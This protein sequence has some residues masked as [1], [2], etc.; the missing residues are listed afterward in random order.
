MGLKSLY[1]KLF[2]RTK[3]NVINPI[4]LFYISWLAIY[5][6]RD[7]FCFVL[8]EYDHTSFLTLTTVLKKGQFPDQPLEES[9]TINCSMFSLN[10]FTFFS[11]ASRIWW[12]LA[13]ISHRI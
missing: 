8:F 7:I 12:A 5:K 3:Y 10:F 1:S 2:L 9:D 11:A 4:F 6:F 13:W